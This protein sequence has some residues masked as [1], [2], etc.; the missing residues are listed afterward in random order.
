MGVRTVWSRGTSTSPPPCLYPLRVSPLRAT[1]LT[2]PQA[3]GGKPPLIPHLSARMR[4]PP[5]PH[6]LPRFTPRMRTLPSARL[7]PPPPL[8]GS[9]QA[10]RCACAVPS[11][12]ARPGVVE[13]E[14][15]TSGAAAI[16][17]RALRRAAA[18][19][20]AGPRSQLRVPAASWDRSV[21]GWGGRSGGGGAVKAAIA[22]V[23]VGE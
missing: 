13:A 1:P 9:A 5:P 21:R 2:S 12:A 8:A 7:S 11:L 6:R 4:R 20:C 16:T 15:V 22:A 17:R 14:A 23:V 19:P 18:L 3:L 10:R